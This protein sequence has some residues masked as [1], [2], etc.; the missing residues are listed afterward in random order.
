MSSSLPWL[1]VTYSDSNS[2]SKSFCIQCISCIKYD[3]NKCGQIH[4]AAGNGSYECLN[5]KKK[6]DLKGS[7]SRKNLLIDFNNFIYYYGNLLSDSNVRI[8]FLECVDVSDINS[9]NK[10]DA[11]TVL[12]MMYI[13]LM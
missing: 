2:N 10:N 7:K 5:C 9:I 1:K 13:V 12:V 4:L 6:F 11:S 3:C 8:G